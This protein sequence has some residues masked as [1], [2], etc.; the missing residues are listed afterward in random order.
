MYFTSNGEGGDGTHHASIISAVNSQEIKYAA[1]TS[2]KFD[3][4]L[5]NGYLDNEDVCIIRMNEQ[6]G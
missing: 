3:E 6:N 2:E 4:P 5:A 1:H